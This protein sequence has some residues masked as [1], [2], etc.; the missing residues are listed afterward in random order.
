MEKVTSIS[1][2][3]DLSRDNLPDELLVQLKK[4]RGVSPETGG[5]YISSHARECFH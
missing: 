4:T 1:P 5:S 3:T 2:K